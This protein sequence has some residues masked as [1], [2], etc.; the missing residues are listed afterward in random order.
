MMLAA[1]VILSCLLALPP[2]PA[3]QEPKEEADQQTL[4]VGLDG[5]ACE[6]YSDGPIMEVQTALKGQGLYEGEINR[7]L[8]P[9]TMMASGEPQKANSP[10]V[11]G[12]P[13]PHTRRLQLEK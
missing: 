10:M 7:Q 9:A 6:P 12:V 3:A 13:S 8:D 1:A 4:I 2:A 5:G 11:N